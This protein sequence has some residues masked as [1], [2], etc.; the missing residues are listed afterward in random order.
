MKERRLVELLGDGGCEVVAMAER[1]RPAL[2]IGDVGE[3]PFDV[4]VGRVWRGCSWWVAVVGEESWECT[5]KYAEVGVDT[6]GVSRV[7]RLVC[8]VGRTGDG[9]DGTGRGNC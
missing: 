6:V 4:G 9:A 8:T 2:A 5:E 3:T 1:E 7:D